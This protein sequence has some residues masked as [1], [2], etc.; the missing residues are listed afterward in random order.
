MASCCA[1]TIQDNNTDFSFFFKPAQETLYVAMMP[2]YFLNQLDRLVASTSSTAG[3]SIVDFWKSEEG[4]SGKLF[5]IGRRD[6]GVRVW[7]TARMHAFETVSS[8][9]AEGLIRWAL[10]D[11]PDAR[12]LVQN[13]ALSMAP[14]VD[15][16]AVQDG[17]SG[18]HRAP[19]CFARDACE[20]PHWNAIK[21]LVRAWDQQ[22]AP[23]VFLDLHGPGGEISEIYFYAPVTNQVVRSQN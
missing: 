11:D 14:M 9:V 1:L 5:E 16:D 7:A 20:Q 15:V 22:G 6:A 8:W 10:S 3:L 2:P 4:R 17:G 18:K 12:W 21:A 23:D 19:I 13:A